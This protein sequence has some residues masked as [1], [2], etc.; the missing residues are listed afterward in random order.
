MKW[1]VLLLTLLVSQSQAI[2]LLATL[3]DT[4]Y[5]YYH[6]EYQCNLK[7]EEF[8]QLLQSTWSGFLRGVY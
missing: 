3:K 7:P 4:Y 8:R 1:T 6:Y 2:N 5:Y